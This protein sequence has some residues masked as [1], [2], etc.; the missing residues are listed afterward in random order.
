MRDYSEQ[1]LT[2]REL[3]QILWAAQG[4]TDPSR[5]LRSAPSAGATYPIE[6]YIV[7]GVNGVEGL[8]T[9]VYRY[10]VDSHELL[11]VS[12]GDTRERLSEAS[13]G[14]AWIA[15]APVSLVIAAEYERTTRRYGD[16]GV[17]YVHMEAGHVAENIYLEA[18]ALNLGTVAVGAFDDKE[19]ER[20]LGLPAAHEPLYV[21]PIGH[22]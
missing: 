16:R 5:K 20:V 3:S 22:I 11:L 4:I 17:R 6:I 2:L 10:L 15:E 7:T 19:V 9:G 1:P 21:M 13:L 14:Q 18:A 12:K 8:E